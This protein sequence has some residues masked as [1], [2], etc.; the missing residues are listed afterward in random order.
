MHMHMHADFVSA[1][2]DRWSCFNGKPSLFGLKLN[3]YRLELVFHI[4]HDGGTR[5]EAC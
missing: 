2:L 5:I 3:L 4:I 1:K